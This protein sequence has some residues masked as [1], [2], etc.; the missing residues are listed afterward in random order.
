MGAVY[1]RIISYLDDD[2]NRADLKTAGVYDRRIQRALLKWHR[3]F[4]WTRDILE[5]PIVFAN[6][7]INIQE[8][9]TRRFMRYR[10]LSYLRD[11]DPNAINQTTSPPTQGVA[12]EFYSE[13]SPDSMRDY[14]GYDKDFVMYRAGEI[15]RLRSKFVIKNC[16]IGYFIDPLLSPVANISSWIAELYPALVAAEAKVKIFADLGK[17][18]EKKDAMQELAEEAETLFANNVRIGLK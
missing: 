8:I 12:G 4:M 10:F 13:C 11:Y 9:D 7:N 3:K 5:E 6:Q 1:N 2:V 14:F 18:Q 15:L 17:D 16:M